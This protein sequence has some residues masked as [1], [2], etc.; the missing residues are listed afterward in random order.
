[1]ILFVVVDFFTNLHRSL[2]SNCCLSSC[3][4]NVLLSSEVST[5]FS[6]SEYIAPMMCMFL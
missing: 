6:Y 3:L 2:L 5:T 4:L 1:M